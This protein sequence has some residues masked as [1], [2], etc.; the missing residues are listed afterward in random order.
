MNAQSPY[1]VSVVV[2]V[3]ERPQSPPDIYREYSEALVQ[4][5][6]R[7]EFIFAIQPAFR[8]LAD[9]LKDLVHQGAPIRVLEYGQTVSE[10]AMLR[11]SAAHARAPILVTLPGYHQSEAAVLPQ[12]IER[13]EDG[14][15]LAVAWRYPRQDSWVNRLRGR[16]LHLFTGGLAG[17]RLHDVASGVRALRTDLLDDLRLYGELARF[18]PLV[19]R[20]EGFLVEEVPSPVHREAMRRR[21]YSLATYFRRCVDVGGII[22]LFK[23][24]DRPLRFFGL[25]GSLLSLFGAATLTALFIVRMNGHRIASRPF[26]L[27][28]VLAFVIG[29]QAIAFGLVGEMIVHLN[30]PRRVA[31]RLGGETQGPPLRERR[32]K[33]SMIRRSTATLRDAPRKDATA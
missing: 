20:K 28:G 23:F 29:I 21:S 1:D 17:G 10:S 2:L 14:A 31:Y 3:Q 18:L 25:L 16:V 12:L 22:F 4:A 33:P 7:F 6:K 32:S 30:A 13:V 27:L 5:G 19:A 24:T 15:D 11:V 26:L 9:S 8:H